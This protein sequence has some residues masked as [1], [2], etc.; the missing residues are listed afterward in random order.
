MQDLLKGVF[1]ERGMLEYL[2]DLGAGIE[3]QTAMSI[4][5]IEK[6]EDPS[7]RGLDN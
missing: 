1:Y 2:R 7:L 4:T 5:A 3:D 6:E